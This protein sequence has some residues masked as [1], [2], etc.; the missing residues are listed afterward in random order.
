M[1]SWSINV[2]VYEWPAVRL[3]VFCTHVPLLVQVLASTVVVTPVVLS[4]R[5]AVAQSKVTVSVQCT[6]YQNVSVVDPVG[7]VKVWAMELSPLNGEAEP[8][9]AEWVPL[10]A[11]ELIAVDPERVQPVKSPVSNPPLVMP[12]P[13]DEV[14][15]RLT[16]VLCVALGA[17]PV[18]LSV[19]VPAAAVPAFTVSVEEPPVVTA[20]G[21]NEAEAPEGTP[22]T[23]RLMVSADPLTSVVLMVEVPWAFCASVRL[24]GLALIEKS[25][26]GG[27]PP[28][29]GSLKEPM[30]VLQ[31]KLPVAFRYSL[32]YQKVQSSTGSTV[33]AL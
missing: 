29:F 12:P 26:A 33:I 6:W 23:L 3:A 15:V 28:Q 8:T 18:T 7:A 30:R 32:V 5:V 31:L 2:S 24:L 20:V 1:S 25:L 9:C 21:F 17:V 22:E 13:P 11:V 14:T 27:G 4:L 19:Y 10:W 16:G